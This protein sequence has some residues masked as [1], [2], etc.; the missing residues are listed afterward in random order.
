MSAR[1]GLVGKIILTRFL[2]PF[3][4]LVHGP[5]KNPKEIYVYSRNFPLC[6]PLVVP[7]LVSG[8]ISRFVTFVLQLRSA[9]EEVIRIRNCCSPS[10]RTPWMETAKWTMA[11]QG[12]SLVQ[13]RFWKSGD[14]EIQKCGIH[15]I[16]KT[17][18]QQIKIH[19]AQ[20]V[21]K[22]W[23]GRKKILPA[24]FGPSQAI[25]PCTE[26][27]PKMFKIRVFSLVGQCALSN[28]FG[29]TTQ[30]SPTY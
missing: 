9:A 17:Q 24:P 11:A 15:K 18:I 20:D 25:F 22:V 27:I 28:R 2:C 5:D 19:V 7:L 29:N 16:S 21:G 13:A 4:Y 14:L 23:I 10:Q 30:I 26:Q 3:R 12:P 1:H 8:L 6:W